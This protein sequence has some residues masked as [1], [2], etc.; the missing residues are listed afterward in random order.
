[1][2][3]LSWSME[4]SAERGVNCDSLVQEISEK[5]ISNRPRNHSCNILSKELAVKKNLSEV[6]L[7]SFGLMVLAKEI[8]RHQR[9]Y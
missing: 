7:K 4:N 5:N 3:H 2:G 1:M 9:R 8:S 6:K